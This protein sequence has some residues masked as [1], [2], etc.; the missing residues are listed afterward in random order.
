MVGRS[1][2]KDSHPTHQL[3]VLPLPFSCLSFLLPPAPPFH[4]H[5]TA[6]QLSHTCSE[7]KNTGSLGHWLPQEWGA[8]LSASI[9]SLDKCQ[10][11]GQRRNIG[12]GHRELSQ[13]GS[14]APLLW[15]LLCLTDT[16][17]YKSVLISD[18]PGLPTYGSVF[19]LPKKLINLSWPILFQRVSQV[20]L[21]DPKQC[22]IFVK[23][24]ATKLYKLYCLSNKM[25]LSLHSRNMYISITIVLRR[26]T[27]LKWGSQLIAVDINPWHG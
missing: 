19:Q 13:A 9:G 27:D 8:Q 11:W 25:Y 23:Q 2:A 3:H 14:V 16:G 24:V 17:R 15:P 6:I 20:E 4:H 21:P 1:A 12:G 22:I 26:T 18:L 10:W 5:Y 7:T